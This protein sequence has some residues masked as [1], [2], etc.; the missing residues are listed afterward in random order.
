VIRAALELIDKEGPAALTMRRLGQRLGVE[1]MSLYKHVENKEDVIRGAVDLVNAEVRYPDA[2]EDNWPDW[3][4]EVSKE[5]RGRLVRH[6]NMIPYLLRYGA[7]SALVTKLTERQLEQATNA[8]LHGEN[9]H[10]FLHLLTLIEFGSV[11]LDRRPKGPSAQSGDTPLL[12]EYAAYFQ[13]CD[14]EAEFEFALN[15]VFNSFEPH[16]EGVKS[17]RRPKQ[18]VRAK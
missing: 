11:V 6:P 10:H 7:D 15:L 2:H 16:R 9:V 14:G 4:H 5:R 18:A 13:A 8:G 12:S 3:F 17:S 1:A